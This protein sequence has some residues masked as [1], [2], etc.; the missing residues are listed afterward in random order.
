MLVA[1]MTLLIG[2][3]TC[4]QLPLADYIDCR[5]DLTT[6]RTHCKYTPSDE[7]VSDVDFFDENEV[8]NT[9]LILI[10]KAGAYDFLCQETILYPGTGLISAN[11]DNAL[12]LQYDGNMCVYDYSGMKANDPNGRVHPIWR[13]NWCALPTKFSYRFHPGYLKIGNGTLSLYTGNP[14]S[15]LYW[16][17]GVPGRGPNYL[18]IHNNGNL[19][20]YEVHGN[21]V[22]CSLNYT[23]HDTKPGFQHA[24][25]SCFNQSKD[26]ARFHPVLPIVHNEIPIPASAPI[27]FPNKFPVDAAVTKREDETNW[28]TLVVIC[29]ATLIGVTF[30]T[31]VYRKSRQKL[32]S[33]LGDDCARTSIELKSN[34]NYDLDLPENAS[35]ILHCTNH[36]SNVHV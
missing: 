16:L 6:G 9:T 22:W 10:G 2:F 33:D 13:P 30:L 32:T 34:Q 24:Y 25:S 15:R 18:K 23:F 4:N 12:V 19:C 21:S 28:I 11:G 20:L 35:P 5:T 31:L 26:S 17:T 3:C 14:T 29:S 1:K 7:D 36:T 8:A 27:G